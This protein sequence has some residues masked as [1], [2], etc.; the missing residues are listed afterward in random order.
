M[1]TCHAAFQARQTISKYGTPISGKQYAIAVG[2]PR[3]PWRRS[4]A[5]LQNLVKT[6]NCFMK[7]NAG[8]AKL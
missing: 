7:Q 2:K 6:Y 5:S 3:T 4:V 8:M 1:Q